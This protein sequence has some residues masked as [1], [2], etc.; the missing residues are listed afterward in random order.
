MK[1]GRACSTAA[2]GSLAGTGMRARLV[3]GGEICCTGIMASEAAFFRS[4]SNGGDQEP[5]CECRYWLQKDA[6]GPAGAGSNH[7]VPPDANWNPARRQQLVGY[8]REGAP[9]TDTEGSI[10]I[11]FKRGDHGLPRTG[12]SRW[13]GLSYPVSTALFAQT[14]Y[15]VKRPGGDALAASGAG[16]GRPEID[17]QFSCRSG[18]GGGAVSDMEQGEKPKTPV[19]KALFVAV[20]SSAIIGIWAERLVPS[21][22][23]LLGLIGAVLTGGILWLACPWRPVRDRAEIREFQ[24]RHPGMD[25]STPASFAASLATT[26]ATLGVAAAADATGF[27]VF[28]AS[29]SALGAIGASFGTISASMQL[30]G[31]LLLPQVYVPLSIVAGLGVLAATLTTGNSPLDRS[32]EGIRNGNLQEAYTCANHASQKR[33]PLEVSDAKWSEW[34]R[35]VLEHMSLRRVELRRLAE[36]C[37]RIGSQPQ[38]EWWNS[39]ALIGMPAGLLIGLLVMK[40][41]GTWLSVFAFQAGLGVGAAEWVLGATMA[42]L[43]TRTA[44]LTREL[45]ALHQIGQVRFKARALSAEELAGTSPKATQRDRGTEARFPQLGR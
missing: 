17:N 34:S 19:R 22:V 40:A 38:M 43:V 32:V 27:G 44:A 9:E 6:S 31:F 28:M 42:H 18:E 25:T 30:L 14:A 12:I 41:G 45:A 8:R 21:I 39:F 13:A 24:L 3:D 26:A 29:A 36:R 33:W 11:T 5:G 2:R 23:D 20:V 10:T 37:L 15:R 4:A 16:R 35:V 1:G 7:D